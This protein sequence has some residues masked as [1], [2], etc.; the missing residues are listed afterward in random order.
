MAA[1]NIAASI[2]SHGVFHCSCSG[3]HTLCLLANDM[4]YVLAFVRIGFLLRLWQRETSRAGIKIIKVGHMHKLNSP[5]E[6]R[7]VVR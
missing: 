1:S 5:E 3:Q 2:T 4:L 7:Y 6:R